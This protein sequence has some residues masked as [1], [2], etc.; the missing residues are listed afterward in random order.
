LRDGGRFQLDGNVGYAIDAPL[1]GAGIRTSYT[2]S[3]GE[4]SNP[5]FV[6]SAR[7]I[8][9]SPRIG[10]GEVAPALQTLS[11]AFLDR[12]EVA[13]HLIVDYG[14]DYDSVAYIQRVNTISPFLRATYDGGRWGRVRV[15]FTAG[16]HPSEL[17][18]RD[19][20]K[21][22]N[23]EQDFIALAA[24]PQVSR[25]N[26]RLTMQR[27]QSVEIS[28][29]KIAGSR[30]YSAGAF[31]ETVSNASFMLSAPADFV[32]AADVLPDITSRSSI[33]NVGSY[34]RTG[35]TAAMK[36]TLG[37]R[38]EFSIAAGRTGALMAQDGAPSYIDSQDL[39]AGLHQ[40]QRYWVTLRV[41]AI[42]PRTGTRVGANYG[43]TDFRVLMPA[44]LFITQAS[45]QDIGVNVYIRQPL[46][47]GGMPWRM[48]ATAELRNLLAQGYLPVGS[49]EQR[50]VLTNA[51]R[52]LRGGLNFIF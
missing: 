22:G 17:L 11:T 3:S 23:M 28:W 44:H 2:H 8:Y 31:D 25:S 6:V 35:V 51:P 13:D 18:A 32:P 14:F 26:D 15:G 47:R 38:A 39:R 1:P 33:F 42:M 50:S 45:N 40:A 48:E 36:Q 43:W 9:L 7:Q 10:S 4:G 30:T 49:G 24:L 5:E 16:T 21:S 52:A 41:A 46:P 34:H 12:V 37:D 19:Q 29:E 27:N 20:E